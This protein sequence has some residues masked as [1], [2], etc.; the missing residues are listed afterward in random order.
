MRSFFVTAL[1]NVVAR[2]G[3]CNGGDISGVVEDGK[4]I[5]ATAILCRVA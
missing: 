1:K 3:G 2:V 5:A 4:T